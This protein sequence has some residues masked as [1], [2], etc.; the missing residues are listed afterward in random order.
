[1]VAINTAPSRTSKRLPPTLAWATPVACGFFCVRS[2]AIF[3]TLLW[4]T[5]LALC[6][7]TRSCGRFGPARRGSAPRA[8][9]SADIGG[10]GRRPTVDPP[11]AL[12]LGVGLDQRDL[13][14]R[15]AG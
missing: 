3:F 13:I 14:G 12:R 8:V 6:S 2:S 7:G 15:P 5:C 9:E 10:P 1:M 4:Y 11:Q